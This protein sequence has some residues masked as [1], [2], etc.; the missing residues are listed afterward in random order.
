[1]NE[2]FVWSNSRLIV[3]FYA[4]APGAIFCLAEYAPGAMLFIF[5]AYALI[6][7]DGP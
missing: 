5:A 2:I 4:N 3:L 6:P 1:M 7:F